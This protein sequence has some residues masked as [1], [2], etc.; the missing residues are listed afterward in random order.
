[1]RKWMRAVLAALFSC[2]AAPGG[3]P[4]PRGRRS[5]GSQHRAGEVTMAPASTP[6]E[7]ASMLRAEMRERLCCGVEA[8]LARA[9][10]PFGSEPREARHHEQSRPGLGDETRNTKTAGD[11]LVRRGVP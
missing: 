8:L 1:M 4:H 11:A 7:A 9:A 3:G 10:S 5:R 6:L 2:I